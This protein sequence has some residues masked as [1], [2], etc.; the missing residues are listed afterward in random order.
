MKKIL[1]IEDELDMLE[2]LGDKFSAEN[3]EVLKAKNGDEGLEVSLREHPD[4]ILLDL[5]MPKMDGMTTMKKLREDEWG[6]TVPII[7]LT[8]LSATDEKLI[9]GMVEGEPM[10]Y[11]VKSDWKIKDV[12]KKVKEALNM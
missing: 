5:V 11:L 2:V 12:V 4:I 3:F 1:I 6:K 8:N 9:M 7:I 10:Y